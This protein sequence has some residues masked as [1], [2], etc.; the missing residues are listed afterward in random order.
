MLYLMNPIGHALP[1]S[2][3]H[4]C[5]HPPTCDMQGCIPRPGCRPTSKWQH[6]RGLYT[7]TAQAEQ[8]RSRPAHSLASLGHSYSASIYRRHRRRRRRHTIRGRVPARY[9]RTTPNYSATTSGAAPPADVSFQWL[10]VLH[11]RRNRQPPRAVPPAR[12]TRST[13][14]RA[15][16][17]SPPCLWAAAT[18][19]S[20]M[21]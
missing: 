21:S 13:P 9:P 18:W 20:S 3:S 2:R 16:A 11:R 6:K 17:N 7:P 15:R 4:S 1:H 10:S 12:S 8:P 14:P 5:S 19:A